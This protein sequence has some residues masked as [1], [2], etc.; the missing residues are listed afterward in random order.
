MADNPLFDAAT[1]AQVGEAAGRAYAAFY[2]AFIDGF[3][4]Q[5]AAGP[6]IFQAGPEDAEPCPHCWC[7]TCDN[8]EDCP[9]YGPVVDAG[10]IKP[11]PCVA[12]DSP[13]LNGG[14]LVPRNKPPRCGS[15]RAR[16]V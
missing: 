6:D 12:C 15:Y 2:Q 3:A 8:L 4:D 1:F 16:R 13:E 11:P 9:V 10:E 14:A 5:M 7:N